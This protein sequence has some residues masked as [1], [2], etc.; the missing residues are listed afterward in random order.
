MARCVPPLISF[1]KTTK[2]VLKKDEPVILRLVSRD[3][4]L[5]FNVKALG[6]LK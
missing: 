2:V 4:L 6:F 1:R 5:G 3:R